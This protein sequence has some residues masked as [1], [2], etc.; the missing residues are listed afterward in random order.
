MKLKNIF[1][2]IIKNLDEIDTDREEILKISRQMIRNCSVAIKSIHRKEYNIYQ[3][4]ID[5]IKLYHAKLLE[6]V[7]KNPHAF[8]RFLKTPEQEYVEAICLYAIINKLDLPDPADHNVS[9]VNYLL[10]LADVIGEL[11]RFILDKIRIGE[12]DDLDQILDDMEDIY[13]YLFS[14]DYPKGITQDLRRK[15]DVA[16]GII[17]KTRGD[18]SLTIQMN[19][20]KK[21]LNKDTQSD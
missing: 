15:T 10:G 9:D 17:E 4:K 18:I 20:L 1:T 14:L 19:Q 5:E 21:Q 16:R 2:K 13:S 8:S 3:D 7:E 11:R 12:I 6:I